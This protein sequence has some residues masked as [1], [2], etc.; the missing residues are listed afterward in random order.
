M[1]L[2]FGSVLALL[3]AAVF[4]SLS[5]F[6]VILASSRAVTERKEVS[7]ELLQRE[8]D[9]LKWA[10]EVERFANSGDAARPL[11][12]QLDPTQCG[13]GK[14]YYGAGRKEAER[15]SAA[16]DGSVAV[17]EAIGEI[18]KIRQ[19]VRNLSERM[20][21]FAG[22][23]A[24]IGEILVVID[25]VAEQATGSRVVARSILEVSARSG[26]ISRASAEQA[27][28]STTVLR[29]VE[30]MR[31]MAQQVRRATV[32]QASGARII[33][34]ASENATQLAQ[35]VTQESQE[36]QKLS[37]RS[38]REV[39]AVQAATKEALDVVSRMREIVENFSALSGHLKATLSQFR[40]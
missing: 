26:E 35:Q 30:T 37:E 28:D 6:R 18:E 17:G 22:S 2:G 8:V 40:T 38:V 3:L 23:V 36:S 27:R 24:S 21:H 20:K 29:S 15:Q 12:V 14:W 19:S 9:H 10:Q 39:A 4:V 34:R 11:T 1:M 5:G 7:A 33:A 32:E 16:Q 13:F 31:E 25:E